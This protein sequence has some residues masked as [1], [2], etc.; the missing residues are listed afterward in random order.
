M[1]DRIGCG[2]VVVGMCG[3]M[4][5]IC[6]WLNDCVDCPGECIDGVIIYIVS[7]LWLCVVCACWL[8]CCV[9]VCSPINIVY[10]HVQH[11]CCVHIQMII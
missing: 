3:I 9:S 1:V 8:L 5:T 6:V 7:W 4:L 11:C 2:V 10:I